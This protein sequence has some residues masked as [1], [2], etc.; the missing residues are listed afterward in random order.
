MTAKRFQ[1]KVA[2]ILTDKSHKYKLGFKSKLSLIKVFNRDLRVQRYK[3]NLKP[4]NLFFR[5]LLFRY[6]V[7]YVC[8]RFGTKPDSR[9]YTPVYLSTGDMS[10]HVPELCHHLT[11]HLYHSPV[12][13]NCALSSVVSV[14]SHSFLLIKNITE[15]VAATA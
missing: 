12:P 8:Y 1:R 7:Y 14:M 5:H 9:G 15:I 3:K 2:K 6:S 13:V 4:Q 11:I 10:R